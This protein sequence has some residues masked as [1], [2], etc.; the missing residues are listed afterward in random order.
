MGLFF[1]SEATV[2]QW[3]QLPTLNTFSID[4]SVS[5]PDSGSGYLGSA[6]GQRAA[7]TGQGFSRAAGRSSSLA[8]ASVHATIIDLDE[9]D[10]MI[11]AHSGPKP[12]KIALSKSYTER[13]PR[14]DSRAKVVAPPAYAYMLAMNP[15]TEGEAK[16]L[17]DA[18]YYMALASDAK[19]KKH[20][21]SVE[22]Y[23][24]LAWRSLPENRRRAAWQD[25]M[26]AREKATRENGS[27]KEPQTP[28]A[29][30]GGSS[31]IK[32]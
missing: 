24:R 5:V 12:T 28:G 19:Q 22:L 21:G 32:L 1:F 16:A 9:L 25:L 30:P 8:S 18:K 26:E 10:Q 6:R 17:D 27:D 13:E 3:V 23:Y 14:M 7:N 4:S 20:W 2:A 29:K 11:R 31:S 15:G